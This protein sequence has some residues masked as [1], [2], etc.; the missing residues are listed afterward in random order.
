VRWRATARAWARGRPR[1]SRAC[2]SWW[3][4]WS[5]AARPTGRRAPR[6]GGARTLPVWRIAHL[7]RAPCR[8]GLPGS[9]VPRMGGAALGL[10]A[11]LPAGRRPPCHRVR[12]PCAFA[13]DKRALTGRPGAGG[14]GPA[15]PL[16][17]GR[18]ER[19]AHVP[20]ADRPGL[21]ED[22]QQARPPAQRALRHA[23]VRARARLGADVPLA[24]GRPILTPEPGAQAHHGRVRAAAAAQP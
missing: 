6:L 15:G 18:R 22:N 11:H 13:C 8:H 7:A 1:R 10:P 12:R 24:A 20:H 3:P 23:H 17:P 9:R 19:R 2:W 14:R 4:S 16:E 5:P 21:P